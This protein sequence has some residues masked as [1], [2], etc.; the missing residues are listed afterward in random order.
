V[1]AAGLSLSVTSST[2][3]AD[4]TKVIGSGTINHNNNAPTKWKEYTDPTSN[5]KYYSDG[6]TT[7]W[8]RPAELGPEKSNA[9]SATSAAATGTAANNPTK[10][11]KRKRD[12]Q[13]T[14]SITS[15]PYSSKSEATAAFK[16]LLLAKAI[17][18]HQKYQE[19]S[20]LCSDDSRWDAL[21]TIGERKQALA[22]YQTKRNNELKE[23]K[24]M[25]VQQGK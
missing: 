17:T 11:D 7:T 19:V 4:A 18:P 10:K 16:G 3:N 1:N 5:K 9:P 20:K 14:S 12:P 6:V 22:E 21:Q 2:A 25:E 13:C 8:T 15:T 23:M 24:R